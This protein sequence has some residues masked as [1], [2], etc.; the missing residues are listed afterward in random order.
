MI[1]I[2][3]FL[4]CTP[5]ELVELMYKPIVLEIVHWRYLSSKGI[6]IFCFCRVKKPDE[7][8]RPRIPYGDRKIKTK[9]P[10]FSSKKVINYNST[11]FAV[12]SQC[13]P[14]GLLYYPMSYKQGR[15]HLNA[16]N[17][18]PKVVFRLFPLPG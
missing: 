13:R 17:C 7:F 2:F 11:L 1:F 12:G 15:I 14:K 8:N 18:C 5:T 10:K 9:S 16:L 4:A 3:R 6:L